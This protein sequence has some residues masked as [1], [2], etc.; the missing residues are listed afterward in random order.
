[1]EMD[2]GTHPC[3]VRDVLFAF[4]L[5]GVGELCVLALARK[6]RTAVLVRRSV[7]IT[8]TVCAFFSVVACGV[9]KALGRPLSFDLLRLIRGAAVKSSIADR[10]TWQI[11]LSMIAVPAGFS[12]SPG[13]TRGCGFFRRQ[14]SRPWGS[15]SSRAR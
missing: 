4:A 9:F 7:L 5:G 6:P 1:M 12:C 3:L 13:A 14:S 8:A 11:V 10:L 15:G 2:D